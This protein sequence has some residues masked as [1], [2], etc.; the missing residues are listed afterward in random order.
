MILLERRMIADRHIRAR[1][2]RQLT[3]KRVDPVFVES[4]DRDVEK[5]KAR[6]GEQEPCERQELPLAHR[7]QIIPIALDVQR[8]DALDQA[9]E[10]DLLEHFDNLL[11]GNVTHWRI[12]YELVA[13]R[14]R[15]GVR[16]LRQEH[17]F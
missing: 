3:V 1:R 2:A 14:P 17:D 8:T 12:E 15:D 16:L 5:G 9:I 11:I 4:I 10:L 7:K 13:K 6:L